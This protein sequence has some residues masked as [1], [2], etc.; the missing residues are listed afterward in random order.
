MRRLLSAAILVS[1]APVV[2]A[3]QL[4]YPVALGRNCV[5]VLAKTATV[6]SGG[7]LEMRTSKGEATPLSAVTLES[8]DTFVG[9]VPKV[10]NIA[11]P[12]SEVDL[13]NFFAHPKAGG[14]AGR[15][16]MAGLQPGDVS[17]WVLQRPDAGGHFYEEGWAL[18]PGERPPSAAFEATG[19]NFMSAQGSMSPTPI[20]DTISFGAEKGKGTVPEY[21][22]SLPNPLR[23]ADLV[24][25][26]ALRRLAAK[27]N[28][29]VGGSLWSLIQLRSGFEAVAS[30]PAAVSKADLDA[31]FERRVAARWPKGDAARLN[32]LSLRLHWG[33][34]D[35]EPQYLA[36]LRK[37]GR[38][39]L[40]P[41]LSEPPIMKEAYYVEEAQDPS[42]QVAMSGFQRLRQTK[43]HDPRAIRAALRWLDVADR[44]NDDP[45]RI[46][47]RSY[48]VI[49]AAVFYLAEASGADTAP[50]SLP[51]Y[52]GHT[53]EQRAA[54][55]ELA[56][57]MLR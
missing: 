30:F 33:F 51:D 40:L 49:D 14:Y 43:S 41:E 8:I 57:R 9:A 19:V 2:S 45:L 52:R 15:G 1:L 42:P 21:D 20:V 48:G 37:T 17:I 47:A 5:V 4:S 18:Q 6:R 25:G 39:S 29:Y 11:V 27:P 23:Y 34:K 35:A 50:F 10:F 55:R 26:L 3:Q 24:A 28:T 13:S 12:T 53:A 7:G 46:E 22:H 16:P 36:E 44:P 32:L 38:K 54:A 56:A 31:W